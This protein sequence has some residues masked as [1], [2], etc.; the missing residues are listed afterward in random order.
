MSVHEKCPGNPISRRGFLHAGFVGGIGL[1]LSDYFRL[2]AAQA[3]VSGQQAIKPT[4]KSIIYIFLQ[5]GIAQQ[6]SWDPKPHAPA[7]YRGAFGSIGTPIPG[8]RV[9][10]LM[11]HCSKIVDKLT[12][13]R[14]MSHGDADHERSTHIMFTG[15]KPSPAVNYPSLGSVVAHELGPRHDLP[16]YITIPKQLDDSGGPGYLSSAYN[17][18]SLGAD[19]AAEDFRVRDLELPNGVDPE[20][21]AR[22]RRMLETVNDHFRKAENSDA[23]DAVDSFYQRAYDMMSSQKAREAFDL[24]KEDPKLRDQYGR[25]EAGARFLMARRLVESGVR[26]VTALYGQWDHHTKIVPGIKKHVPEFDQAFAALINDLEQRGMLD[27][28]LVCVSTEFGRTPM[29]NTEAGRDHWGKVFSIAMAG[30]GMQRGLVFGASDSIAAEPA[31]GMVS[32]EDWSKTMFHCLGI[33]AEKT[34]T[35]PGGRPIEIVRGG[36]VRKELLI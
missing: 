20:R 34:L 27:S 30:G 22:R 18:F 19:P 15:Y 14:A 9:N 35:A 4:A 23:L 21:F 32:V 25:N 36:R 11:P 16:P 8:L 13:C 5:G 1:T 31:D 6:E 7:E 3:A 28:T 17:T 29:M 2:Q 26:F 10:E 33:N 12:I 24:N